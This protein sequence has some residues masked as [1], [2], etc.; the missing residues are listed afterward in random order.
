MAAAEDHSLMAV[1][2][3]SAKAGGTTNVW[4]KLAQ[5]AH[6]RSTTYFDNNYRKQFEDGLRMFNSRHPRD[7]KYN[8]DAYRYRSRIFRP[9]TRSAIRKH[10]ATAAIAFF[11]NPDIVAIDPVDPNN[12]AEVASSVIMK[13]LLTYRLT[14]TIPWFV[15][16]I[17]GLQ[18]A[19]TTGIVASFQ[20]WEYQTRT[21]KRNVQA[22][23]PELGPVMVEQDVK[24]PIKDKPC[25]ELLATERIRF[26]P[27]AAWDDVAG[28]SPYLIIEI[29]MYVRDIL[30]RIENGA[31]Y[32]EPWKKV[33]K[34]EIL[35]AR[36]TDV[37]PLQTARDENRE[38]PNTQSSDVNEFDVAMVRL[39]FVRVGGDDFT[40]YTL[41]GAQM[42]TD[43]KPT[44]EVFK[45]CRSGERP[46]TIGFCVLETHKTIKSSLIHL[47]STLQQEANEV[48]NQRLDNVKFVLNKRTLARRGANVDVESLVRNV[49]GGVT[50]VNDIEKDVRQLEYQDVTSSAYA[51]QDRI[52]VD[53]DELLGSFAQSSVMTN[54]KLNETVGGMRMMAQGAN[55]L[56]EYT[57]RVFT[58]TWYKPTLAQIMRL[59]QFYETDEVILAVA[60]DKAKLFEKFGASQVTDSLLKQ[61]LTL[62]INVGMGSTDPDTRFQRFNQA[63]TVYAGLAQQGPPDLDLPEI[64]KEL[65]SLAGW[66][67]SARFFK[68]VDVRYVQAKQMLQQAEQ[69]AQQTIMKSKDQLTN[70]SQQ[71][72]KREMALQQEIQQAQG[73]LGIQLKEMLND[74]ALKAKDQEFQQRLDMAKAAT[75]LHL[76]Q[77]AH[78]GKMELARQKAAADAQLKTFGAAI[79]AAVKQHMAKIDAMIKSRQA[80][81]MK[82]AA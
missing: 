37:N 63:M 39:N 31:G 35:E 19:A 74:F 3:D 22:M 14:K 34:D 20:Y 21:E 30:D 46:V 57:I 55:I 82:E 53:M 45:H 18:D 71:L 24:I 10:E 7:S 32:G 80:S 73:E 28:T 50:M 17:G 15:T 62:S 27:A 47:G 29:P 38:D 13:E 67:D 56:T 75:N 36:M 52:N 2:I 58:E 5:D 51:E 12:E 72:D 44:T 25:V 11:S 41:G 68:Q 23:H 8:S 59:E 49:P 1:E 33:T 42:L 78:E 76:K 26:D 70:R 61:D 48:V 6:K 81:A 4:L 66:V 16:A 64:R 43:A 69:M 77:D 40:Y 79:D 54:R 9:K 60:A 65:F